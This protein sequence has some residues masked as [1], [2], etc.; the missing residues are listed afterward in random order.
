MSSDVHPGIRHTGYL[1]QEN[2]II[3]I[4]RTSGKLT[5]EEIVDQVP[6]LSW[7]QLFLAM[8]VLSRSGDVILRREGFTYTLEMAIARPRPAGAL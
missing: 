3:E 7:S 6:G 2:A 8:D 4:L 5:I 1:E